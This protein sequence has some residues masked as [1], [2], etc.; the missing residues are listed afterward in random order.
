MP[1]IWLDAQYFSELE[2]LF[3]RTNGIKKRILGEN[4]LGYYSYIISDW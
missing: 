2:K 3:F 1:S 4:I